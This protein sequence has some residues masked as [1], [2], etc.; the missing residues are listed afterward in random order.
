MICLLG[1]A[2]AGVFPSE[3]EL[4]Q[5]AEI[6][7]K[8]EVVE[9][10]CL[11]SSENEYGDVDNTYSA[12]ISVLEVL[13]GELSETSFS[14]ISV[15]TIYA[16]DREPNCDFSEDPHPVGEIGR[17]YLYREGEDLEL[18]E[19][20][21]FADESSSPQEPP[22]CLLEDSADTGEAGGD[23]AKTGC[24]AAQSSPS[25]IMLIPLLTLFA[26]RRI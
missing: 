14:I 9:A 21:F 5:Q 13:Q 7:V 20:G 3:S 1:A 11:Y 18:Y 17:Y 26:R 15:D 19:G 24:S 8:G 12:T 4:Q 22:A 23:E 16:P 2:L 25:W 6:T 10:A